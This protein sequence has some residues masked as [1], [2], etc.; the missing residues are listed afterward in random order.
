M[1]FFLLLVETQPT[2]NFLSADTSS[3]DYSWMFMKVM[4]AMVLVCVGAL[5]VIKYLLPRTHFVR[6]AQ[7]SRIEIVE[8]FT[9]EPKKN[10][11]IL[12]VAKKLILLGTTENSLSSLL[13]L[14]EPELKHDAS[15]PKS[16]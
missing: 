1:S 5:L 3:L 11:Y 7:D 16:K 13:E 14:D 6:R 8:R 4:A 15:E 12:K 9:L 2:P 10:L